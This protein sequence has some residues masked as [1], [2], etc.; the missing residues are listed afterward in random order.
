M[1]AQSWVPW[2]VEYWATRWVADRAALPQLTHPRAVILLGGLRELTA[3][4][5]EDGTDIR[6]ITDPAVDASIA[7]LGNGG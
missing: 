1:Q 7:L 3:M 6:D 5:V 2:W 4:A